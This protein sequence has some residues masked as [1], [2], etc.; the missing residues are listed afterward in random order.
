MFWSN[1]CSSVKRCVRAEMSTV[2]MCWS[3]SFRQD[4]VQTSFICWKQRVSDGVLTTSRSVCC[5]CLS[6]H[7]HVHYSS[8]CCLRANAWPLLENL[9][10]FLLFC[11]F[12]FVLLFF[13]SLFSWEPRLSLSPPLCLYLWVSL[14]HGGDPG[15]VCA[16]G[17]QD[18]SFLCWAETLSINTLTSTCQRSVQILLW[19]LIQFKNS[20]SHTH[21]VAYTV[22]HRGTRDFYL[23]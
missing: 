20:F 2:W 21:T 23:T 5:L 7:T 1:L 16:A 13:P 9:I 4:C 10:S 22:T 11:V 8:S 3:G 19:T 12:F 17:D 15:A 18:W 14:D 6:L